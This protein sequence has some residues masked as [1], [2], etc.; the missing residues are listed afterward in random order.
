DDDE[1]E[2]PAAVAANIDDGVER[3]EDQEAPAGAEDGPGRSPD[4]FDDGIEAREIDGEAGGE[5]DEAGFG[6]EESFLGGGEFGAKPLAGDGAEKHGAESGN[7]T[8]GE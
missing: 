2:G 8:E 3:G 1:R 5:A 7:E 4:A 6:E